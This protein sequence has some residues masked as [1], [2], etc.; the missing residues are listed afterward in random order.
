MPIPSRA[1]LSCL[2]RRPG[3]GT[4]TWRLTRLRPRTL[5]VAAATEHTRGSAEEE[6]LAGG[7]AVDNDHRLDVA[8]SLLMRAALVTASAAA[9]ELP[10]QAYTAA[11]DRST[12]SEVALN[13]IGVLFTIAFAA[14]LLRVLRKRADR[15]ANVRIVAER[16]TQARAPELPPPSAASCFAGA[17]MAS[18]LAFLLFQ[19]SGFID[20]WF[21]QQP[22]SGACACPVCFRPRCSR[23]EITRRPIRCA[24]R[25]RHA[26][27]HHHW[28]QL[29]WHWPI[30]RQHGGPYRPGSADAASVK[31]DTVE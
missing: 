29:P 11:V 14:F 17:A 31:G 27:F 30:C 20:D 25:H 24:Q 13:A 19:L 4:L 5:V 8:V 12:A 6:L 23:V 2:A 7:S 3:G 26:A 10:A 18:V 16:R 28:P 15:A 9:H 1:H 21:T 22:Q